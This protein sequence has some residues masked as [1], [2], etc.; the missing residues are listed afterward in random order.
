MSLLRHYLE[1]K[2]AEN[3]KEKFWVLQLKYIGESA[4]QHFRFYG[5][6]ADKI[7][8]SVYAELLEAVAPT[9]DTKIEMLSSEALMKL[10]MLA[11]DPSLMQMFNQ[12]VIGGEQPKTWQ[13]SEFWE[14]YKNLGQALT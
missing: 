10:S 7:S 5:P 8:Y 6:S 14:V 1:C 3:K 12:L 11:E 4:T 2:R 13:E 9:L